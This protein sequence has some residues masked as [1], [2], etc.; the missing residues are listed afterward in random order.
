MDFNIYELKGE[1]PNFRDWMNTLVAVSLSKA[2]AR[3]RCSA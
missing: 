1:V 3:V 2:R